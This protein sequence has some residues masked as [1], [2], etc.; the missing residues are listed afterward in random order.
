MPWLVETFGR[1][2]SMARLRRMVLC[3]VDR[4]FTRPNEA[5]EPKQS[6]A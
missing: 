4:A 2:P 1:R 5:A 3:L 6:P